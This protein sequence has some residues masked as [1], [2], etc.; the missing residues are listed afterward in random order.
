MSKYEKY[1]DKSLVA[2]YVFNFT[3]D[4]EEQEEIEKELI[5]RGLK[6]WARQMFLELNDIFNKKWVEREKE[7]E[8]EEEDA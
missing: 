7:I 5:R 8:S 1:T 6:E 2:T 4:E 3:N